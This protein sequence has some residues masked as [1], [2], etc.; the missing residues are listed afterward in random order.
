V[1][2]DKL[3]KEELRHLLLEVLEE[4]AEGL[5]LPKQAVPCE[6]PVCEGEEDEPIN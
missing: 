6:D 5:R 1:V 2:S 4:V 3:S